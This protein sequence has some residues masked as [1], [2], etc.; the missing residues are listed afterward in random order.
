MS[1]PQRDFQ[2]GNAGLVIRSDRTTGLFQSSIFAF[3]LIYFAPPSHDRLTQIVFAAN[4]GH[5]LFA[6]CQLENH[7]QLELSL[8]DA[9][10]RGFGLAHRRFLFFLFFP[11]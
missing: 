3:L 7:L 11:F 5:T 4:L 2:S 8:K 10:G 6:A 9:L 1:A